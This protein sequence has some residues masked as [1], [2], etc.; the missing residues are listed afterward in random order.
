M[1]APRPTLFDLIGGEPVVEA[2]VEAFYD[3]VETDPAADPLHRLHLRGHG[4]AHSR[5]EQFD[6]LC[7]FLGG[8]R[9]FTER[10][11]PVG[12]RQMHAHVAIDA[13][14]RDLWLA[15]MDRAMDAA[16]VAPEAKATA[17]AHFARAAEM[18][19]NTP[20]PA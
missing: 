4:V 5:R 7:G 9:Y 12:L 15:T 13:S 1:T 6:F 3:I 8:P 14:L 11:G 2:L 16:H 18:L 19:R 10:R 17:M 20:G